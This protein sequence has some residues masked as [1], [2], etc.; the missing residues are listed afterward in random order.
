MITSEDNKYLMNIIKRT[1]SQRPIALML[2][3]IEQLALQMGL[4]EQDIIRLYV[5]VANELHRDNF[6]RT[7]YSERVILLPHCLRHKECPAEIHGLGYRCIECGRCPIG[8]IV[9]M[10]R[11]I[12]YKAV[13]IISGS[14][15]ISE[16][17]RRVK[18]RAILGIAC[19]KEC[20]MGHIALLKAGIPGQAVPLKRDGCIN[21]EVDINEVKSI[22]KLKK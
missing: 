10:A 18:P 4:D 11:E 13:Y 5:K 2:M 1:I 8:E 20:V 14:S 7:P 16:I 3:K 21:T 17:I 19:Y 9:H 22:M 12:G 6:S 15:V